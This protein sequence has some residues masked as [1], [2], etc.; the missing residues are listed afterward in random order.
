MLDDAAKDAYRNRLA[1]LDESIAEAERHNDIGRGVRSSEW[2][3]TSSSTNWR[4]RWGSAG[5]TAVP[6]R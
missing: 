1:E 5:A 3:A 6:C 4:R 2:S